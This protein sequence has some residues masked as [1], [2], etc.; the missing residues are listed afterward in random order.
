M[1]TDS[2]ID[3]PVRGGGCRQIGLLRSNPSCLNKMLAGYGYLTTGSLDLDSP[4]LLVGIVVGGENLGRIDAI[5]PESFAILAQLLAELVLCE[6]MRALQRV[7]VACAGGSVSETGGSSRRHRSTTRSACLYLLRYGISQNDVGTWNCI[8]SY[9]SFQL[10][11]GR[12]FLSTMMLSTPRALSLA[13]RTAPLWRCCQ[14]YMLK[15]KIPK[16][17]QNMIRSKVMVVSPC[18]QK[19]WYVGGGHLLETHAI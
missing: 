8:Q 4:S 12:A 10:S 1:D 13:A 11:P 2:F 5:K 15:M 7:W 3:L 14:R 17:C 19:G 18:S 9:L 16:R 6:E